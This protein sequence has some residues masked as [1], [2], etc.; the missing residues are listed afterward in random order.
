M[1]IPAITS[2]ASAAAVP[3][4]KK[5]ELNTDYTTFLKM[6]TTQL[7][8]QDPLNPM[9]TAETSSQ[10]AAFSSVEQQ[11]RTNDL[12]G[13]L[14]AQFSL[15][16]MSQLAIWVG[17]EARADAPVWY[18]GAAVTLS[19]NPAE[20]ADRVVLV[21]RDASGGVVAREDMPPGN[22]PYEWFGADATGNSLPEGS[23]SL[24]L[25]NYSGDR[26]LGESSVESYQRIL[27][28]RNGPQG[29]TL[30]LDGGVEVLA[31]QITALRQI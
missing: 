4:E 11:T 6:L 22:A 23:Y 24:S 1:T 21:V 7:Q 15:F 16:G 18:S 12:L 27:E 10:L 31:T 28:A 9:D 13:D 20:L 30:V 26:L 5:T 14:G 29:T 17:Q 8:N 3:L 19:P 2:F 25:E